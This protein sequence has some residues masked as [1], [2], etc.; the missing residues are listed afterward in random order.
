[1]S[2]RLTIT[3]RDKAVPF[4]DGKTVKKYTVQYMEKTGSTVNWA[5]AHEMDPIEPGTAITDAKKCTIVTTVTG[6]QPGKTYLFRVVATYTDGTTDTTDLRVEGRQA[7]A[8][9]QKLPAITLSKSHFSVENQTDYKFAIGMTGKVASYAKLGSGITISFSLLV[10]TSTKIDRATGLLEGAKAV[11][12]NGFTAINSK[13]EFT[14]NGVALEDIVTALGR[15]T[16]LGSKTLSFQLVA[17][18]SIGDVNATA[19]SKLGRVTMPSWYH[20]A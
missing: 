19:P 10:S 14:M 13:G 9:T 15:E 5:S 7:T 1:M 17:T 4:V 18:F 12:D 11:A 3:D 20:P 8:R 16:V 2:G 6:L